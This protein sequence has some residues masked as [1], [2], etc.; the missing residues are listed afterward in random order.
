MGRKVTILLLAFPAFLFLA[1]SALGCGEKL[2]MLGRGIRF[3]TGYAP[4]PAL[5]LIYIRPGS[6]AYAALTDPKLQTAL[7]E[8][9]HKLSVVEGRQELTEALKSGHYDIVLADFADA[10]EL[11]KALPLTPSKPVLLPLVS[12]GTKAEVATLKKHYKAVMKAPAKAGEY[13]SAVD[14]AMELKTKRERKGSARL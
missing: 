13:C 9:G 5:V 2:L 4:Q 7:T 6:R 3:Q 1:N 11:E 10:S 8:A 14:K 12:G